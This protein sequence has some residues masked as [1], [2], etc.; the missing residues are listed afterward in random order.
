MFIPD[1]RIH[2]TI[3]GDFNIHNCDWLVH[4]SDASV[5]GREAGQS[6]VAKNLS[7]VI[8]LLTRISDRTG[9]L[10]HTVDL[11]L[12]LVHSLYNYFFSS[13]WLIGPLLLHRPSTLPAITLHH[14]QY[15]FWRHN[16]HHFHTSPISSSPSLFLSPTGTKKIRQTLSLLNACK[17]PDLDNIPPIVL[18][19]C[20]RVGSS[21][22]LHVLSFSQTFCL[23]YFLETGDDF[24]NS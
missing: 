1:A 4:F 20:A 15:I 10:V 2:G 12:T 5:T 24:Q 22:M 11:S 7:Q 17:P 19:M 14:P 13:P 9:D 8:E 21:Y 16:L 23:L 3:L 6:A 18:K